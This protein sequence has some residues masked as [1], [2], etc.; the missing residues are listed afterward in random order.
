MH[1]KGLEI[2]AYNCHGCPGMALSFGTSPIGAHH[3]DAWVIS[4]EIST[5]RFS[6]SR[7]KVEKVIELQRLRGGWFE[8]LT[9]CR[10]PWVEVDF[11]LHW[12]PKYLEA[13]RGEGI[14]QEEISELGD[15]IYNVIRS[16]W[17]K[18]SGSWSRE[19]DYPPSRWFKEPLSQGDL[20]GYK[21]DRAR[22][23]EMLSQYYE[24]R[25]WDDNGIPEKQTLEGL[26]L[27]DIAS[28]LGKNG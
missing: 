7:E 15:R 11:G 23:G 17:I 16:F 4:W 28:V 10:L 2:S 5:D 13:A 22:Y 1:V 8:S 19:M 20:S 24:I 21:L 25:G 9:T 3:K 6:Y 14:T 27:G 26:G 12:Y 18:E